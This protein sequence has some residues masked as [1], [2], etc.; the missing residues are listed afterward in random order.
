[1]IQQTNII[2]HNKIEILD[3]TKLGIVRKTGYNS[4]ICSSYSCFMNL[5]RSPVLDVLPTTVL[6]ILPPTSS[7][8]PLECSPAEAANSRLQQMLSGSRLVGSL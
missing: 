5:S 1:M 2:T 4:P 3:I 8:T 6:P 7:C